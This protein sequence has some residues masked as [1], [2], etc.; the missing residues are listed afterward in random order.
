MT[1]VDLRT[2]ATAVVAQRDIDGLYARKRPGV[3][4]QFHLWGD[5]ARSRSLM[6]SLKDR[7]TPFESLPPTWQVSSK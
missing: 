6:S 3:G 1:Y 5:Q 2:F 7:K 4:D